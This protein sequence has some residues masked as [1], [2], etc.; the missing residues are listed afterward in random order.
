MNILAVIPAY[1]PSTILGIVYP[2]IELKRQGKI[3][4]KIV[5][6]RDIALGKVRLSDFDLALFCRNCEVIDLEALLTISE[7]HLPF[8]YELDDNFFRIPTSSA[9]GKYHRHPFRLFVVREFIR[10]ASLI[11]CYNT[12]LMNDLITQT[13]VPVY[14]AHSFFDFEFADSLVKPNSK[15]A[16]DKINIAFATSRA[17]DGLTTDVVIPALIKILERFPDKVMVYFFGNFELDYFKKRFPNNVRFIKFTSSY[18]AFLKGFLDKGIDI[19][20]A[21]LSD[22]KFENSKTENKFREYAGCHVAGVYSNVEIYSSNITD[23]ESGLLVDNDQDSWY[24]ALER[25]VLDSELRD[26][27]KQNSLAIARERYSKKTY[28]ENWFECMQQATLKNTSLDMSLYSFNANNYYRLFYSS[29][30]ILADRFVSRLASL[31]TQ[32]QI[33]IRGLHTYSDIPGSWSK[34]EG[35]AIFVVFDQASMDQF[36]YINTIVA[37]RKAIVITTEFLSKII[38]DDHPQVKIVIVDNEVS[39]ILTKKEDF[40]PHLDV[41]KYQLNTINQSRQDILY[42]LFDEYKD[43]FTGNLYIS[44]ITAL[45]EQEGVVL[46]IPRSSS[47]KNKV[48]Q[49][50]NLTN[51][52]LYKVRVVFLELK[53]KYLNQL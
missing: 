5:N 3:N 53:I 17:K 52:M 31:L 24:S 35:G 27:I 33:D 28:V 32:S 4:Y 51:M 34:D 10:K 9:I 23:G 25:L 7:A 22:G 29:E 38:N 13:Q 8:I 6:S 26:S 21:P 49:V 18:K 1:I 37:P 39:S 11:R 36:K 2:L 45:Y 46:R 42:Y 44:L 48:N 14:R 41:T 16:F 50:L 20:L 12:L 43:V 15:K 40:T 30:I 19:G 47:F